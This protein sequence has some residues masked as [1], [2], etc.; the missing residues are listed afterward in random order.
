MFVLTP[1]DWHTKSYSVTTMTRAGIH[2]FP[3]VPAEQKQTIT[4]LIKKIIP[5]PHK[6]VQS[7]GELASN[8]DK[9]A[10]EDFDWLC[11]IQ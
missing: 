2:V 3:L 7:F 10:F 5:D 8:H 4:L 9:P 11:L 1:H 6:E